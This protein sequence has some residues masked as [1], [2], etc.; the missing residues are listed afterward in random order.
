MTPRRC[1]ATLALADFNEANIVGANVV[2][3]P[4]PGE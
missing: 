2:A 4:E 1:R 3:V